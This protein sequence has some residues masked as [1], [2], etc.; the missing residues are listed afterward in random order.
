VFFENQ[1]LKQIFVGHSCIILAKCIE[2]YISEKMLRNLGP[3][4][5]GVFS[6]VDNRM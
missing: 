4:F 2:N 3:K 1:I 5:K 6:R